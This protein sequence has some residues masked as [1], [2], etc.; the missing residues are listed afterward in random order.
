MAS[1]WTHAGFSVSLDRIQVATRGA[2]P[3]SPVAAET[4]STEV[5]L[6]A[7]R[8]PIYISVTVLVFV[9]FMALAG[10]AALLYFDTTLPAHLASAP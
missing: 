2:Q 7:F 4:A 9:V 6:P 5:S 3:I 1:R 10:L 8:L